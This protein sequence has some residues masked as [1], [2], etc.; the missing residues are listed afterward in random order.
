M[1]VR[2]D[3]ELIRFFLSEP[4]KRRFHQKSWAKFEGLHMWEGMMEDRKLAIRLSNLKVMG[5]LKLN[6]FIELV[7]QWGHSRENG[8]QESR[9][10]R[11]SS[12][13]EFN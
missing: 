13:R 12:L 4:Q 1:G 11:V 8:Q 6:S 7:P 9:A 5:V 3:S 10:S 2:K